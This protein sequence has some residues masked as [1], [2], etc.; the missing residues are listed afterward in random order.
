MTRDNFAPRPSEPIV[1]VGPA[2]PLRG[3]IAQF[4]DQLFLHLSQQSPVDVFTFYRL[5]PKLFFPGRTQLDTSQSAI[6]VPTH[7]TLDSIGPSSWWRT[8]AAIAQRRPRA[9]VV[10]HQM[11]FFAPCTGTLMR[12]LRRRVSAPQILLCHNLIPH[13]PHWFDA[14][15][16]LSQTVERDL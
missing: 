5:F 14:F 6:E 2:H 3:G 8:A 15:I 11:P 1:L 7:L 4:T 13:E 16:V 12:L 9:I 10:M